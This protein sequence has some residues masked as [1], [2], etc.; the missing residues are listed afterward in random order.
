MNEVDVIYF[1]HAISSILFLCHSWCSISSGLLGTVYILFLAGL[2]GIGD[3]VLMTQL[4]ALI[5]ILFKHDTVYKWSPINMFTLLLHCCFVWVILL[6]HHV[7]KLLITT[8]LIHNLDTP[9]LFFS[10]C[11]CFLLGFF[12]FLQAI[13]ICTKSIYEQWKY[14][15]FVFSIFFLSA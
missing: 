7:S 15:I 6:V 10:H 5:G 1:P 3:G 13:L 8:Y 11:T 2:L 4:N 14:L 9:L 12:F